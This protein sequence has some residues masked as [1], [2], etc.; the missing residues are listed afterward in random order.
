MAAILRKMTLREIVGTKAEMLAI[1]NSGKGQKVP[2]CE[3]VGQVN[4]IKPGE[5]TNGSFV[6]LMGV[7]QA[8]NLIT[9][10]LSNQIDVA[11]LPNYVANPIAAAVAGGATGVQFGIRFYLTA[12]ATSAVGYV[13]DAE[14]LIATTPVKALPDLW[15]LAEKAAAP[16]LPAPIADAVSAALEDAS[17]LSDE[18]IAANA[19]KA[20]EAAKAPAKTAP[21]K[22]GKR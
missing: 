19:A 9:G 15:A 2:V 4:A 3:I 16:R 17:K 7:F 8:K 1:A 6:K 18:D 14:D 11:I 10:E 22:S 20:D 21:A 12:N 5:G 13:F